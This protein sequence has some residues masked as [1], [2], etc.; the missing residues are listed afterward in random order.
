MNPLLNSI[1]LILMINSFGDM[2]LG[3]GWL[4]SARSMSPGSMSPGFLDAL[5]K[6]PLIYVVS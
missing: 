4:S 2:G 5:V 1:R 6:R 3:L